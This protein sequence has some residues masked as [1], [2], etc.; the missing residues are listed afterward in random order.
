MA[1]I[2]GRDEQLHGVLAA[3]AE[4]DDQRQAIAAAIVSLTGAGVRIGRELAVAPLVGGLDDVVGNNASGDPQ[5]KMDLFAHGLVL[6]SLRAGPVAAI[7][8]EEEELPAVLVPRRA[9]GRRRRPARRLREPRHQRSGR[10]HLLD[11]TQH[12]RGTRARLPAT[13][14]RAARRRV[15]PLRP[16]DDSRADNRLGHG[17]LRPVTRRRGVRPV[18]AGHP[19]FPPG[20]PNTRSTRRMPGTGCPGSAPTSRTCRP[21]PRVCGAWTSACGG[22][23]RSSSRPCGS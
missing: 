12:R 15:H 9:T 22:T 20:P 17:P 19:G 11:P 6:E 7:A 3:W 14:G 21:G 23:A 8:S 5:K 13:R 16:G 18:D 4:D 2:P 10:P 1:E